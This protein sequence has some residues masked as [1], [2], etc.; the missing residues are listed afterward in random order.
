[1]KISFKNEDEMKTFSYIQN[2]KEF[3]TRRLVVKDMFLKIKYF[4][5]KTMT[6]GKILVL[7]EGIIT[8]TEDIYMEYNINILM[9]VFFIIENFVKDK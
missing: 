6:P 3:I 5:K 9:I 2:M 7:E 1:M 8:T 4:R